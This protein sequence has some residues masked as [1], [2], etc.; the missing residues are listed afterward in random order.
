[1]RSHTEFHILNL[2][3][4]LTERAS[5]GKTSLSSSRLAQNDITAITLD[6]GLSM[7]KDGRDNQASRASYVH[8]KAI[9]TLY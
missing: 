5:L 9:G 1:M 3:T 4:L 6:D 2:V 8:D 7:T